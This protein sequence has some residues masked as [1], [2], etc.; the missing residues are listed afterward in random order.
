MADEYAFHASGIPQDNVF[1][2]QERQFVF[3]VDNNNN[4]YPSGSI[5]FD[6]ASLSY[7]LGAGSILPNP[8]SWSP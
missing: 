4:S 7:S 3:C 6:L 8:P 1:D 2:F 5:I